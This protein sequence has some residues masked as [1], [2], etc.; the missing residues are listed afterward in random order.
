MNRSKPKRNGF[1]SAVLGTVYVILG[2]IGYVIFS[3]LLNRLFIGARFGDEAACAIMTLSITGIVVA[4]VLYEAIFITWQIKLT[5][6]SSKDGD[7]DGGMK[8][9][10]R[11]VSIACISLSLLFAVI[12]SNTFTELR[13]DSISKVCFVTTKQYRWDE[14]RNDVLRYSFS[15]DESGNITFNVTMKDGEVVELLGGVTSI[16][17]SFKEKYDAD[18][19]SLLKY[20]ADLSEQLDSNEFNYIIDKKITS[21]TIENA[22]NNYEGVEEKA[23]IWEQIERIIGSNVNE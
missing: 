14:E 3:S 5:K 6:E 9:L 10:L 7:T 8:K 15:C 18:K 16:S 19:V 21:T 12:S 13:E 4:F 20:A 11:I 2:V 22:R 23:L 1:L 17:D